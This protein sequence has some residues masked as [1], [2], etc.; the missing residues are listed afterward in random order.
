MMEEGVESKGVSESRKVKD[1]VELLE[2]SLG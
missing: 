1:L 2:E